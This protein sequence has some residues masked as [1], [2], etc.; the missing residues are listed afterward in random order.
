MDKYKFMSTEGRLG[1]HADLDSI[2]PMGKSS[3]RMRFTGSNVISTLDQT[4]QDFQYSSSVDGLLKN[5]YLPALNNVTFHATPLM[6][7]FGDFGG[8]IDF[9]ANKIIKA[10]K[11]QGAGGFGGIA[12]GG[13]WVK[14]RNQK[15]FQGEERIKYL[16]AYVSLTGPGARTVKRGEGGYV[17]AISSAMDDTLRLAKMQMERIIGGQGNGEMCRFA[18]G[19]ANEAAQAIGEYLKIVAGATDT[20]EISNIT[21]ASGGGYSLA[22]WLQPGMRVNLAKDALFDADATIPTADFVQDSNSARAVYEIAAVNYDDGEFGLKLVT[23]STGTAG[24]VDVATEMA[25]DTIVM[26]LENA[27]GAIEADG[28]ATADQCLEMNGLYNLIS[29]GV[30]VGE[31][32]FATIWGRNRTTAGFKHSLKSK[33]VLAAGDELDEELMMRWILDM[34]NIR[35]TVPNTMIV[36]PLARIKYFSNRKEDRRFDTAVLDTSFGFRSLA[37]TIDNYTLIL[38]SL[39]SLKPGTLFLINAGD[40]KYAKGTEGFEWVTDGPMGAFRQKEGSDNLY[41]TAINYCN[42]V[43]EN[44]RGQLKVTGLSTN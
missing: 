25:N 39:A 41:A 4:R 8:K 30:Q 36:D 17:D 1:L 37:V 34:A 31:T 38:Q 21:A 43:C 2:L 19:A 16:N 40:F 14:G 26:V 18:V 10:F 32:N 35:Q 15:G 9:M 12:E 3:I 42:F 13:D 24:T 44:P 27:Y 11:Y 28:G 22:Q 23:P 29:D 33:V 20:T 6:E 7:M 5:V